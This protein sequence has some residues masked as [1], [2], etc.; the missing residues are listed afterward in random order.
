MNLQERL[1]GGGACAVPP[2]AVSVYSF[3][4]AVRPKSRM[5]FS[6]IRAPMPTD[7]EIMRRS[8]V[9]IRQVNVRYGVISPRHVR[10]TPNNG[11]WVAHPSQH[12][13]AFARATGR[14]RPSKRSLLPRHNCS[15]RNSR[16]LPRKWE[17][18]RSRSFIIYPERELVR[19]SYQAVQPFHHGQCRQGGLSFCLSWLM[20]PIGTKQTKSHAALMS[21]SDP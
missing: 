1:L 3:R 9:A 4:R 2:I 19:C 13:E 5:I 6:L 16:R 11:S 12:L 15:E 21:A 14:K 18:A 8:V 20:S 10:F 17:P 7:Q